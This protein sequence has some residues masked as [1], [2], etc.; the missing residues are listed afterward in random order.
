MAAPEMARPPDPGDALAGGARYLIE[1]QPGTR[2]FASVRGGFLEA[3]R[4]G[5][6]PDLGEGKTNLGLL[7]YESIHEKTIKYLI[8]VLI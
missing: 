1:V 3:G 8:A 5:N 4:P 7:F 6:F 2:P